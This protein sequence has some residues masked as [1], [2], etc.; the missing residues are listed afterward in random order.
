MQLIIHWSS[1]RSLK[2]IFPLGCCK[3]L[4]GL[5]QFKK[6]HAYNLFFMFFFFSCV[7]YI[8]YMFNTEDLDS[9]INIRLLTYGQTSN[10]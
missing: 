1:I 4:P 9:E 3:I 7:G 2:Y 10:L 8:K 5:Q 6:H